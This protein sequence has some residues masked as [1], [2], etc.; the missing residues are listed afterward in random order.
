M[1]LG[2]VVNVLVPIVFAQLVRIFEQGS[3][4]SPWPYLGAYV[5]LRFLQSSGGLAALRDVSSRTLL[6]MVFVVLILLLPYSPCG[7]RLCN[8]QTEVR[9][10]AHL[11]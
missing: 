8:T 10:N 1:V 5:G 9:T 7:C 3:Q 2:R 4:V 11:D 6:H